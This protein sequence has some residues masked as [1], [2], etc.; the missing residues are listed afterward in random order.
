M[1]SRFD[2]G[3]CPVPLPKG[4]KARCGYLTVPEN[5]DRSN[6]KTIRLPIIVLKSSDP[7]PLP[8]PVLRTFGGPGASSMNLVRSRNSSPWLKKRDLIIFEQRGTRYAEPSLNCPEVKETNVSS[9]KAHLSSAD[10]RRDEIRA[11]KRCY[12]R[13]TALGID[14]S[15]YNSRES[16]ADIEDLRRA[17]GIEKIN[18]WGLSYSSRLM[19]EVMRDHPDGIRSV[20]LESTLPPE[21][22]YDE[23]G[24]DAIVRTFETVFTECRHEPDCA[25]KYP[26]LENEFYAAYAKLNRDPI[27]V[28][29]KGSS[30]GET[31][32]LDGKDLVDWLVDYLLSD[33]ASSV[34]EV[35]LA[36]HNIAAGNYERFKTYA[37]S[38]TD[39]GES[40]TGMRYSVWCGEEFPFENIKKIRQQS[41]VHNR[42]RG[43]EVMTLPFICSTWTVK[44]AKAV[45]NL[46]VKST[47]PTMVITA[48]YDAYTPAAWGERV[49]RNLP[50]SFL[51]QVPWTGHGP[52]FSVPCLGNMITDFFDRP[53]VAPRS[54]C[55]NDL[56]KKFKF[57]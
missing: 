31:V 11:A 1:A 3:P 29:V 12:D 25:R 23:V 30:I 22:N 41:L 13:L 36:I 20:V 8:D 44:H 57:V 21:I 46:P 19:L 26:R 5:R 56:R 4:E 38:K 32:R 53:T 24:V 9:A 54:E 15:A 39:T 55:L 17:L 37:S 16:A 27:T 35:P 6:S 7:D 28:G 34:V 10:A 51:Y 47:I 52:A 49:A 18:L 33:S 50:H 40:G 2:D 14:L 48:Q 42:L 43:Y 45:E